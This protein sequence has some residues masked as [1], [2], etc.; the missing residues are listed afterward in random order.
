MVLCFLPSG[1]ERRESEDKTRY[2]TD[3]ADRG[4]TLTTSCCRLTSLDLMKTGLA[5][6]QE[7]TSSRGRH[8]QA[9]S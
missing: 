5:S 2:Y 4:L 3:R 9:P 8:R 6:R 7:V 1:S